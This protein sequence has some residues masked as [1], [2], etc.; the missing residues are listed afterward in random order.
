M[1]VVKKWELNFKYIKMKPKT[2]IAWGI[3]LILL[4]LVGLVQDQYCQ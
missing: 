4:W 2:I 1:Y 3:I